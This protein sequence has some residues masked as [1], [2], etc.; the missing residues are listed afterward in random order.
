[1]PIGANC[2][3][4][5]AKNSLKQP[6]NGKRQ[7]TLGIFD[8]KNRPCDFKGGQIEYQKMYRMTIKTGA[9]GYG[10]SIVQPR[11]KMPWRNRYNLWGYGNRDL[12]Q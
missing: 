12:R 3:A 8:K 5:Q 7:Q 6:V 1:M 4:D 9:F 2:N 11:E 10:Y